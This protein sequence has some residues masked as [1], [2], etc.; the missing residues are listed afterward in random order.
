MGSTTGSSH[1]HAYKG[2]LPKRL[3]AVGFRRLLWCFRCL[4]ASR[5][6]LKQFVQS[7]NIPNS[8][9]PW[10]KHFP[11]TLK[12]TWKLVHKST[13]SKDDCQNES[14]WSGLIRVWVRTT[15]SNK[16]GSHFPG[17]APTAWWQQLHQWHPSTKCELSNWEAKFGSQ[18]T[19]T[20]ACWESWG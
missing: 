20:A 18:C 12:K 2:R 10:S 1:K 17:K 3:P 13:Q 14:W 11:Q 15:L 19:S 6:A 4:S 9:G 7:R 8:C 5:L 16:L